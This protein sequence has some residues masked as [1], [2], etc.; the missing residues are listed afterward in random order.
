[1]MRKGN[2][3]TLV[4]LALNIIILTGVVYMIDS[5][6]PI[7]LDFSLGVLL[8]LISIT[9]AL[10]PIGETILRFQTGCK[11]I[12]RS[13]VKDFIEPIFQEVYAKAKQQDMSIPD[14][15]RLF[16]Q[17]DSSANAFATGRKTV[18]VTEGL[19]TCTIEEIKA[20]LG[21]EF[22]HLAHKDTDIILVISVGNLLIS[23]V[24]ICISVLLDIFVGIGRIVNRNLANLFQWIYTLVIG[25]LMW[26][27]TWIGT[28]LVMKS[29]RTNEFEADAFSCSLGY[30]DALCSLLDSF[31]DDKPTGL[32]AALSSSHPPKDERIGRLKSLGVSYQRGIRYTFTA[33][34]FSALQIE[35]DVKKSAGSS[36]AAFL[37]KIC[38][39]IVTL[40]V[41]TMISSITASFHQNANFDDYNY[42]YKKYKNNYTDDVTP[43]E[44]IDYTDLY[45]GY[46]IE[47]YGNLR[48]FLQG[49]WSEPSNTYALEYDAEYGQLLMYYYEN[50]YM[51]NP[52]CYLDNNTY[53]DETGNNVD[54]S[55]L[56]ELVG[57]QSLSDQTFKEY[58]I[59]MQGTDMDNDDVSDQWTIYCPVSANGNPLGDKMYWAKDALNDDWEE[60]TL[61]YSFSK[62]GD[63]DIDENDWHAEE[64][65]DPWGPYELPTRKLY[66]DPDNLMSGNDVRYIQ[67]VLLKWDILLPDENGDISGVFDEETKAAVMQYQEDAGLEVD[68]IVGPNTLAQ[69]Q[70]DF[71]AITGTYSDGY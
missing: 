56:A 22:G 69:M 18:C 24:I 23:S 13:D 9:I 28:L 64:N 11:K 47:E 39:V 62:T 66:Y 37:G 31:G 2:I 1:M 34:P 5:K 33:S 29:S 12:K 67:F 30:G 50:D 7:W 21:H 44:H 71:E 4:Y 46:S 14:D 57:D 41:M 65:E 68:G 27:W 43:E 54:N 38:T 10:S 49:K 35:S 6:A 60:I 17:Y 15:V 59:Q 52:A 20:T 70:R 63:S 8:Y 32:F 48:D 19:L 25:G 55:W 26:L 42:N 40:L 58:I 3:S 51:D 45:T 61:I 16:I 53:I 36:M